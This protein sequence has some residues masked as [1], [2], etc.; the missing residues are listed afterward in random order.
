MSKRRITTTSIVIAA[1]I[2]VLIFRFFNYFNT[3]DRKVQSTIE[4]IHSSKKVEGLAGED[5]LLI[6]TVLSRYS[7]EPLNITVAKHDHNQVTANIE[8]FLYDDQ[9]RLINI[10]QDTLLFTLEHE[11]IFFWKVEKVEKLSSQ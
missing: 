4:D 8:Q 9:N 2:L 7:R 6:E 11:R 1:I 5:Y 3:P 10:V